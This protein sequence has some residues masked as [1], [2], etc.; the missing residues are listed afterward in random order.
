VFDSVAGDILDAARSPGLQMIGVFKLRAFF[1]DKSWAIAEEYENE[2]LYV[3]EDSYRL[4]YY[5]S[6]RDTLN[7]GLADRLMSQYRDKVEAEAE[8]A[9]STSNATKYAAIML[10]VIFMRLGVNMSADDVEYLCQLAREIPCS[11]PSILVLT[12]PTP[13]EDGFRPPGSRQFLKAAEF[14]LQRPVRRLYD[15]QAPSCFSCGATKA[16]TGR[17]PWRCSWCEP[18]GRYCDAHVGFSVASSPSGLFVH[19]LTK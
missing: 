13:E 19:L 8:A 14:Y 16:H 4:L 3:G 1:R 10:G 15:F 2:E 11:A 17:E 18:H 7:D 12:P 6:V 5:T 9:G